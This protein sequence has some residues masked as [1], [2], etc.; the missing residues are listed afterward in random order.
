[1]RRRGRSSDSPQGLLPITNERRDLVIAGDSRSRS[2]ACVGRAGTGM[3][4]TVG[5]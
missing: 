2:H 3:G 4:I 5:F 1:M